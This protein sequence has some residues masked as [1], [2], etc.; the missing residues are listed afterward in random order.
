[1]THLF[2]EGVESAIEGRK[3]KAAARKKERRAEERRRKRA[4][5]FSKVKEGR[6]GKRPAHH[7][8]NHRGIADAK[9]IV[10]M[11]YGSVSKSV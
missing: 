11:Y 9:N 6:K 5:F 1:M 2:G 4:V 7:A 3:E 8:R 10:P